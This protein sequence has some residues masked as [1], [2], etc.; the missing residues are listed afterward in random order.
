M[1]R[2]NFVKLLD[3]V[4]KPKLR[5]RLNS[6]FSEV[7]CGNV[8]VYYMPI[9]PPS[10]VKNL[11]ENERPKRKLADDSDSGRKGSNWSYATL[12]RIC[13]DS[14]KSGQ[15]AEKALSMYQNAPT[16][17]AKSAQGY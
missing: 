9:R 14:G 16:I 8:N 13:D 6:K 12:S 10:T 2:C 5:C 17:C 15:L 4:A 7:F 11:K 1:G 3:I